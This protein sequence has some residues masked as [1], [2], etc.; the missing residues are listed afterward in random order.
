[1]D[2]LPERTR[3]LL[4]RWQIIQRNCH[5]SRPPVRVYDNLLR[6]QKLFMLLRGYLYSAF[7]YQ[8][9]QVKGIMEEPIMAV[10]M[11][12]KIYCHDD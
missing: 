1:L 7:G 9:A 2:A 6:I 11:K 8:A 10:F 5:R 3:G 4:R 12:S